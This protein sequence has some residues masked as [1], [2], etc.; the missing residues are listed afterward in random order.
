MSRSRTLKGVL[1]LGRMRYGKHKKVAKLGFMGGAGGA[2]GGAAVGASSAPAGHKKDGAK[3]GAIEGA[4]TGALAAAGS[5]I[6]FRKVRGR[7]IPIRKKR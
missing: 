3:L 1:R 6:I 7:I 5:Y 2:V 4:A